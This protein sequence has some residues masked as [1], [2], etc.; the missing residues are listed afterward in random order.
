MAGQAGDALKEIVESVQ[1]VTNM[2]EQIATAAEEQSSTGE[3]VSHNI[4]SVS[5]FAKET[6]EAV[7]ASNDATQD[8]AAVANELQ[9]FVDDFKLRSENDGS[10]N[11][12]EV[13]DTEEDQ[14]SLSLV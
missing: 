8:L 10:A 6:A 3:E 5:N 2:A 7:H 13:G 4:E 1:Q 14:N 12:I 9:R 11:I